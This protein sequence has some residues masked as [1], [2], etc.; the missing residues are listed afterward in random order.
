MAPEFEKLRTTLIH[1]PKTGGSTLIGY[2]T[3]ASGGMHYNGEAHSVPKQL[4]NDWTYLTIIRHPWPW[5]R[6]VWGHL[7]RTNWSFN[8]KSE[9]M[10]HRIST[11]LQPTKNMPFD[12]FVDWTTRCASGLARWMFNMAMVPHW[13][14]QIIK[15]E[16][17]DKFVEANYPRLKVHPSNNKGTNHKLPKG[18]TWPQLTLEIRTQ[19]LETEFDFIKMYWGKDPDTWPRK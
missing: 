7:L 19:I 10:W 1:V 3:D 4:K 15:N 12:E 9:T 18:H 5:Y 13:N 2:L 14:L 16:N 6:S 17:L 11:T 8:P